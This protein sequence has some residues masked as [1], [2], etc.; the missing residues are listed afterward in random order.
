MQATQMLEHAREMN[1]IYKVL[2]PQQK[3][4]AIKMFGSMGFG[5]MHGGP[6]CTGARGTDAPPAPAQD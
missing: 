4:K 2:N 6:A 5:P 1:A 3:A